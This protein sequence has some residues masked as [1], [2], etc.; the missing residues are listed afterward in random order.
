MSKKFF[1]YLEVNGFNPSNL[2]NHEFGKDLSFKEIFTTSPKKLEVYQG[3]KQ[4]LLTSSLIVK[5]KKINIYPQQWLDEF[6][7]KTK[8]VTIDETK[9]IVD[10]LFEKMI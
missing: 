1:K 8:K 7:P 4:C 3:L 10:T 6:F 9:V 2:E 5:N